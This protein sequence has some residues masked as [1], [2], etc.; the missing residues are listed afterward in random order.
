LIPRPFS[1]V[2]HPKMRPSRKSFMRIWTIVRVASLASAVAACSNAPSPRP[3]TQTAAPAHKA[4][5]APRAHTRPNLRLPKT[6]RPEAYAVTM[7]MSP[8]DEKIEGEVDVD[9]DVTEAT[10]VVWIH[11]G[12]N[13]TIRSAKLTGS[14]PAL[15]ARVDRPAPEPSGA[16]AASTAPEPTGDKHV[17]RPRDN[18]FIALAF[19]TELRPGKYKLNLAYDG[20]LPARE[21]KGAYRQEEKGDWYIFT[22]FE[23][24]DARRAFPCFDEPGFKTPYEITLEVPKDQLAFANTPQTSEG[25]AAG[26]WKRITFAKSKPLPSYLVAFAV[27]PFEIVDA[28]KAGQ[29]QVPVRIIVPKGKTAEAAYAKETTAKVVE[30]LEKY[31]GMPYPYE[32]LDHIAVPMKGGAM[33]NP[34]LITY[35]TTTMLGKPEEKSIRLQ[36]GYLSIAA[37]ELG[38]IWFGDLVTT[39]WWDDIWLNEAFA[40][41]I[42]A[43]IVDEMHPEW[44]GAVGKVQSKSGAMSTD[45]LVS[46]RRIREPIVTRHDIANAFDAITYQKGAAVI[47]MMEA[48][49]GEEPFRKGVHDYLLKHAHGTATAAEFLSDVGSS[50]KAQGTA[51]PAGRAE[52]FVAAFPTFL[53]QPGVPLVSAELS[54][55]KNALPKLVLTQRRYL[56]QGSS[57]AREQTW[58]IPVC[59]S[60]PGGKSC[61]VLEGAKGE[62]ALSAAKTCPAWVNPN[63]NASGYYR[64]AYEGD[65]FAKVFKNGGKAVSL[66]ERVAILSDAAALVRSGQMQESELLG[67]APGLARESSRHLVA[68]SAGTVGALSDRYVS[69]EDRPNYRR[70]VTK[71]YGA[72]AAQLGWTAKP[73]EDDDTK[74]LRPTVVGLVAH[75]DDGGALAKEARK[76]A[77]AWLTDKKVIEHDMVGLVLHIAG[78]KADQALWDKLH[79]RATGTQDRK[80]RGQLLGAMGASIDPK[81]VEQ[82]FKVAMSDE[83]DPRE[84]LGLITGAANDSKTRQ[85]AYDFVKANY[86]AIIARLPRDAGSSLVHVGAAF[87][88]AEHRAD[89]EAFFKDRTIHTTGGPRTLAQSLENMSLCIAQRPSREASVKA[90]FKKQ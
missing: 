32:K 64:V 46:T 18:D 47:A 80:E 26:G 45:S 90:F 81:I 75:E 73:N 2:A 55:E 60:Y 63:A 13:L 86:D 37:H 28:G 49:V 85:M 29:N 20:K 34:G 84:S 4:S 78:R 39:A 62:L 22:Q 21:G 69:D 82:N 58:K 77:E 5:D 50:L 41:W 57:G 17:A 79:A 43:K 12:D 76:L 11:A 19:D 30:H 67:L 15:G 31:F 52:A 27:G 44:D 74:L 89:V 3:L 48:F 14:G 42:S 51:A 54:C 87:C 24:T 10:H 16:P 59:A 61:T 83:F 70:F 65:L 53:D 36:R 88:D 71:H 8:T 68:M 38:H 72:K 1:F 35:G 56:P 40:T 33:E 9:I 25:P 23:S 66:A 6:V 7:R